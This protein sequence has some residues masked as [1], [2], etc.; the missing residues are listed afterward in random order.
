[1]K[2]LYCTP[3]KD[4]EI[5][6]PLFPD[7]LQYFLTGMKIKEIPKDRKFNGLKVKLIERDT[8]TRSFKVE[9]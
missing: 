5:E 9:E 6:L 2:I 7:R 8:L 1:M 4:F 3:K